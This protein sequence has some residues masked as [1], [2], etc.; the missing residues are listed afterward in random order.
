[1]RHKGA[2]KIAL[3]YALFA[4]AWVLVSDRLL[5]LFASDPEAL[6]RWQTGKG[7]LF[8][9]LSSLLVYA[10]ARRLE[11]FLRSQAL[12]EGRF[13][14][15]VENSREL[16]YLLDAQG[17]MLYAS[18]NVDQVLGYNPLGYTRE[19]L[20]VLDFVHPEDRPY[21]EAALE[22]LIRHPGAT[23]EYRV[24][25]L[26]AQGQVRAVRVWG[27]NLLQDEAVGAIVVN[28]QDETELEAE[29]AR[30]RG[31]LEALPGQVYQARVAEEEDPAYA[32]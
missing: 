17:R 24:R 20:P 10:L 14:S 6:T 8:V 13:R 29:R 1:M 28:V 11:A 12:A 23:R 16:I 18:P 31:V 19:T 21:A 30:L 27:R 32:P 26:D 15:L 22:D 5:L 4:S 2:W 25:I 9:L 7:V 3:A